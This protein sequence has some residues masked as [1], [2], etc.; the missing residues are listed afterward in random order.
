VPR[1]RKDLST[2]HL[3]GTRPEY[4]ATSS[5]V[6]PGRP[7][8]PKGISPDA[9]RVFKNISRLLEARRVLSE[10]DGELLRLYALTYDRHARALEKLRVE[11]EITS[12]TRTD[13]KGEQYQ[14]EGPNL[15]LKIA[16]DSEKYMKSVLADLGL[17]PLMRSKVKQTDAPKDKAAD[18]ADEA[19]LSREVTPVAEPGPDLDKLLAAAERIQ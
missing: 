9:K 2:H 1:E 18:N 12:Y 15:W 7:R 14:S 5:E 3:Q 10:G 13:K 4:V 17:N 16:Q 11:G 6:R 19:L 8:Y